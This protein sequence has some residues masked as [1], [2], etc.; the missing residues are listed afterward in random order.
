MLQQEKDG[1][2]EQRIRTQVTNKTETPENGECVERQPR[3]VVVPT[4]SLALEEPRSWE[5]LRD[6]ASINSD[7]TLSKQSLRCQ[8]IVPQRQ[9]LHDESLAAPN[10]SYLE[11]DSS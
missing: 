8:V 4:A 7:Y 10:C 9:L 3:D 6:A 2:G 11:C 5:C 1:E